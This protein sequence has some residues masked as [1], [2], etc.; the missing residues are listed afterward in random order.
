[1]LLSDTLKETA[2]DTIVRVAVPTPLRKLFDYLPPADYSG[3]LLPGLRVR[4]PFGKQEQMGIIVEIA[5]ETDCPVSKLKCVHEVLDLKPI[6]PDSI[7]DLIQWAS[8]YYQCSLG[9]AFDTAMPAWLRKGR[10]SEIITSP[11]ANIEHLKISHLK[12]ELNSEQQI[13][14]DKINASIGTF[15]TFL[16]Q[17]ITGSGKTEVY[18]RVIEQAINVSKQVLILVPE[19]GLTPQIVD[20]LKNRFSCPIAVLH[21][22]LTEKQRWLAWQQ[23]KEGLA[24]IVV[25]TRSAVFTPLKYPGVFMVDEEH[26]VS[27]KQQDGFRYSA[28]DLIIRRAQLEQCPIILGTATPSLESF[29]NANQDKFKR[30]LLQ[31]RAGGAKPPSIQVLD[32]RHKKLEAGLS[33]QLIQSMQEHL[34]NQGQVL[35]FL[36][37]RGFAPVFMCFECGWVKQCVRCDAKMTLHY[38][39]KRLWCHH[40]DATSFVPT[41]CPNC[42]TPNLN[43]VGV[44]TERLETALQT[45]FPEKKIIRLDR[46][47]TRKK[48]ALKEALSQ[49][50]LGKAEILLGTQMIAKGHHFPNVTLVAIIDVDSGLFSVDFRSLERLGQLVTQVTGRA[51]RETKP[52]T[53]ILQTCHPHHPLLTILLEKGYAA[54]AEEILNERK[55]AMLP[56]YSYHALIRADAKQGSRALNFLKSLKSDL[57]KM[58]PQRSHPIQ[59]LGPT[60]APMERRVGYFRAQLLLQSENRMRLQ[61]MIDALVE[62]LG[63]TPITSSIRWSLDVDPVEMY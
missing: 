21:S 38:Q 11:E 59:I 57:Q 51:G 60:P 62:K 54:F 48:E 34:N 32:I 16:L 17:G 31:H 12:M 50:Q 1:M 47:T 53:M 20:R 36:N 37:R 41:A 4:I 39:P 61:K 18:F 56:P 7:L 23:A 10:T 3:V 43:A 28:R 42:Q 14:V 5:K 30:L 63:S 44:G 33:A 45:L 6:F 27:F 22:G 49:A 19:I 58:Q 26:D 29:Q 52:G 2:S 24:P 46:D 25:G 40:C 55:S 9:E 15:Q 8:R 35:I 13:A